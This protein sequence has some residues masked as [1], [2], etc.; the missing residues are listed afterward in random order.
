[1][2][3][4]AGVLSATTCDP[5][6]ASRHSAPLLLPRLVDSSFLSTL[7]VEGWLT[8]MSAFFMPRK[9]KQHASLA[10]VASDA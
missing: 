2:L 1:M 5:G 3:D 7:D 4:E 6:L 8:G 10:R 9:A